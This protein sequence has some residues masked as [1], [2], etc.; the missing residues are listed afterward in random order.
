MVVRLNQTRAGHRAKNSEAAKPKVP[1]DAHFMDP[2]V[3]TRRLT[4]VHRLGQNRIA[5]KRIHDGY[6]TRASPH[7][8]ILAK[9]SVELNQA[10]AL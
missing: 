3:Y 5:A 4:L 8:S 6:S 7:G 2:L 10:R 9:S 1:Y